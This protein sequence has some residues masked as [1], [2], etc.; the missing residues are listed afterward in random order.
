M[1]K[2]NWINVSGGKDSTAL[3]LWSIEE[4]LPNCRYVY[5]DTK[6]EHP[7]VYEYLDYLEQKTEVKIERVESEGFLEMC[8]RKQRFPSSQARFCTE[9]LKV[10]P[11][12]KYM[13]AA[14]PNSK[15]DPHNV[16]IGIRAEES[17]ARAKMPEV[18]T[19]EVKYP[20][21]MTSY[22]M[23]FHPLLDWKHQDVFNA[24]WRNG[25]NVNPLYKMGMGR[26]GCFPCIMARRSE[27]KK[28]FK[29]CPEV[30]D[31]LEEWEA[32][33]AAASKRGA[34]SFI[35]DSDL[36]AGVPRGIRKFAEYLDDGPEIPG[37]EQETGGCMSVYGLCE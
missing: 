30:I 10:F 12:T 29:Q 27:L 23:N 7:A 14:E 17:P 33:V 32:K 15:S 25:V 5:A 13:D 4:E 6:H 31:R 3:L 24:H 22:T 2:T 21:R 26:V 34:A 11:L 35:S 20:P 16:W 8:I 28:I 9:E 18:L 36:P 1:G 37:L 19:R